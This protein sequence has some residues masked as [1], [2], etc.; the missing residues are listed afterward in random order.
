MKL[1][2]AIRIAR[3]VAGYQPPVEDKTCCK[4]CGAKRN[5]R[6]DFAPY[7]CVRHMFYV[8]S[9]GW[10]PS[11]DTKPYTPPPAPKPPFIQEEMFK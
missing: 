1:T 6:K 8:H 3:K 2:P 11:F 10:C 5:T 7:Y 4:Y 9:R